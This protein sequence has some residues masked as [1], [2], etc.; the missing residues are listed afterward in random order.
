[1]F[2]VFKKNLNIETEGGERS[3]CSFYTFNET[4]Q[5]TSINF[6]KCHQNKFQ[7]TVQKVFF[8]VFNQFRRLGGFFFSFYSFISLKKT[9]N[10]LLIKASSLFF[11]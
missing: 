4:Q 10:S 5:S 11:L 6:I 1:M 8:C 2:Y 7:F 3:R 9:I